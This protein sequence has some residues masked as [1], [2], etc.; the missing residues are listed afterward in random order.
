VLPARYEDLL[1]FRAILFTITWERSIGSV[2]LFSSLS[3]E[4][5]AVS[6]YTAIASFGQP[7][8]AVV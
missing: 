8:A 3:K 7:R 1:L 2:P 5:L 4:V 6:D